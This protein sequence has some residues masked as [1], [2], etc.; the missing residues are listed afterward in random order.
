MKIAI[1]ASDYAPTVGGVQTAVRN[2]AL[3]ST[4]LG[5]SV[6]ILS[7]LPSRKVAAAEWVDGIPVHRFPW[8]RR[9]LVT[10]PFRGVETLFGMARVLAEF[11][12]DL[13]YIHF[14]TINALWVLLLHYVMRFKLV[15]SARGNDIQGI[16]KR[17]RLQRWMLVHLF[18][19]ADAVLFCSSYVQR[20]AAEYLRHVS[21]RAY[22]G[23]VGDGFNADEFA[24]QVPFQ[25]TAPY[26]LAMGRLVE[27]K[28]FDL[29]V[30]AFASVAADSPDLQLLIAGDGE[31]RAALEN[32][33]DELKMRGR[34]S[35]LGFTDREQTIRLFLGCEFFVLSS[36]IEPFGI[37]VL[38]A[39][40]AGKPVLATRSGGVVDLVQTGVNGL[41]VEPDT[42]SL[43]AGIRDLLA[44]RDSTRSMGERAVASIQAHTWHAVTRQFLA[45]FERVV[46][47]TAGLADTGHEPRDSRMDVK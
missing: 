41:L 28:G 38:E 22:V 11:K 8:G 23:V 20:D 19:R 24:G 37:V 6:T 32:L 21:P 31:E 45:V 4:R 10:L 3:H 35:L 36:R 27:K 17:S 1:V 46:D 9:P 16:P 43:A 13:V 25:H 40:A 39:M 26:L 29:L 30:R 14:L 42:A 15:A 47:A 7:A 44:H 18:G 34:I 12:P 2:I 5:H 33:V